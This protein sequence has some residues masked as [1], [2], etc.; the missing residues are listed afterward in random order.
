MIKPSLTYF[1]ISRSSL[2]PSGAS[3]AN[4]DPGF[5]LLP[6]FFH[7]VGNWMGIG[8]KEIKNFVVK[9]SPYE[10]VSTSIVTN[11]GV[12]PVVVG[13][14][15][16]SRNPNVIMLCVLICFVELF[17]ISSV[18]LIPSNPFSWT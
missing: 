3:K 9:E 7:I 4:T 6:S 15:V 2:D 12:S 13:L 17:I 11:P 14:A 10:D 16:S 5:T 8:L 1:F 18:D